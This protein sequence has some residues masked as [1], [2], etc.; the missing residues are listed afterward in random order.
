MYSS[1][2][3]EMLNKVLSQELP[4]QENDD[5]I[6]W[7]QQHSSDP[8]LLLRV[9]SSH[10]DPNAYDIM[11]ANCT[12]ALE[13]MA[14]KRAGIPHYREDPI[15]WLQRLSF[16][17]KYNEYLSTGK[18]D[19][20]E[21]MQFAFNLKVGTMFGQISYSGGPL[22][23]KPVQE[24]LKLKA[25]LDGAGIRYD[26]RP[27][28]G[29]YQLHYFGHGNEKCVCSVIETPSSYGYA[30]DLLEISGLTRNGENV[31]GHLSADEV[32]SRILRHYHA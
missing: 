3:V 31:E 19:D 32:F 26:L 10:P 5:F 29:G 1:N 30:E 12:L 11:Y 25:K 18:T 8:A 15:G 23:I 14:R 21:I 20:P 28:Y 16:I 24:I 22:E 9:V 17:Q 4:P 13:R 27:S 2:W 7:L 6:E